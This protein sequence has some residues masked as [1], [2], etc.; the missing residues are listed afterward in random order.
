MHRHEASWNH[1]R[2][3]RR[4]E[5]DRV[6]E[7]IRGDLTAEK[8]EDDCVAVLYVALVRKGDGLDLKNACIVYGRPAMAA[9]VEQ[10]DNVLTKTAQAI[11]AA[12]EG[13][14]EAMVKG[15][16]GRGHVH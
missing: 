12:E 13:K 4:E 3:K 14:R 6:V 11:H 9:L 2:K 5:L 1:T 10:A 8:V 15:K 16:K 7:K